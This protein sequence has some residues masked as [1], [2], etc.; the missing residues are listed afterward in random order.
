MNLPERFAA[1]PPR[2]HVWVINQWLP[3]DLAPTAV[4]CG[5]LVTVIRAAGH[6][7]VLVS[8]VRGAPADGPGHDDTGMRRIVVDHLPH[9]PTGII[10]KLASWPRFAWRTWRALLDGLKPDDLVVV[11]SDP[12]LF[13]PLAIL[14][15]RRRGARVVHWSQDVYPDVVQRYWPS[16]ALNLLLAPVRVWRNRRLKQA[17]CVVAISEGMAGLMQAAGAHTEVIPNWARDERIAP[18]VLGDSALRRAHFRDADFVVAYSGNLGRVHEFDTLLAA[19]RLLRHEKRIQFLVV[20]SGP[21]KAQ[22]QSAVAQ[23]DL[24][25]FHFLPLQPEA[26]LADTLA[27]GDAHFVSLRSEFEALVLPSKFYS[28]AAVARPVLFC[29][30]V[31]G[32]MATLVAGHQ[33]GVSVAV[34]AGQELAD[35]ILALASDSAR[36]AELGRNARVMLDQHY[37]RT[38]QLAKWRRLIE[39]LGPGGPRNS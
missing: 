4:L 6:P 7:V 13:Y 37:S 24:S 25:S 8:R 29:G 31:D 3:P 17:D 9:G 21:R 18:R 10:A 35:A 30:D 32:E 39:R 27:A 20:G 16:A 5:E 14:A 34:G 33:C 11:C 15:A 22:L 28:V 19:A 12:P 38:A 1:Q 36:C 23:S 2:G 26:Q